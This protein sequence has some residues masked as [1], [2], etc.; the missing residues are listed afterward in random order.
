MN[1]ISELQ[2]FAKR[3]LTGRINWW[4]IPRSPTAVTN[5]GNII[6]LILYRKGQFQVELFIVPH[7]QSQFC[8]HR[9][10]DVDVMEFGLT[11]DAALF[12]N[13]APSCS[14]ED[15]NAWLLG[16]KETVPIHIAPT[17]LHSGC[18][19]TP[20]A[21]LSIQHW[22]HNVPPSSVGLNWTGAPAS[23][24]QAALWTHEQRLASYG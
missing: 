24:E 11:G 21:F 8:E 3:F 5:F 17:D 12:I 7:S 6:S 23:E 16:E 20:Y 19:Y 18:G 13:S 2:Q 14:E 10:P 1:E 22:L 15:V 4:A 9:H